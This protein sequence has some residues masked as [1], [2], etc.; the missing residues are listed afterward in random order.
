MEKI[1]IFAEKFLDM[2]I[3]ILD[4]YV[5]NPGDL[6]WDGLAQLGE[7]TVYDRTAPQDVVARA[8]DAEAVFVNKINMT[9]EVIESLPKLRFI[10]ELATGYN[11]IDLAAATR[12]GVTVCNVPAYSTASVAQTVFALLLQ[13][14]V[15]IGRYTRAVAEGQWVA[16]PDFSFTMG[17]IEELE[18]L[19]MGVYGLGNIGTRVASI[20]HA[21]GM[22]VIS[23]TSKAAD[24]LPPYVRKVAFEQMLAE[25]DV[26]TI[27]A[28][29][30]PQTRGLFSRSAFAAMKSS[31]VLI[32]T[33]RGPI[34]NESDLAEALRG[35]I[36]AGA[37]VDV[38]DREPPMADCPLLADDLVK[39]ERPRLL[40]TPH[41][42]WQSVTARHRLLDVSV[43]NLA[44]FIAGSPQ[45]R[46]N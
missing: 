17:P 26:I 37:A 27:H 43:A 15:N 11:N 33:A 3:V 25:A 41:I 4:G 28:P 31:A 21:F 36:I 34:V 13:L 44:A 24:A 30:T 5:A 18:G 19:T 16:A 42:A 20:A 38:L 29:L 2:K 32:N 14:K 46:V 45:N 39:G 35:G 23:P 7:L 9:A 6:S 12:C 1:A 22:Q 8:A 40:I 10:G